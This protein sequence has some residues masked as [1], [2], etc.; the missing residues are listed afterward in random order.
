MSLDH[1]EGLL[2]EG[3]IL[4][5]V[6]PFAAVNRPSLPA[7][8][9]QACAL[10]AGF[11]VSVLY[12]NLLLAAEIGV[13]LYASVS[14]APPHAMVGERFFARSAH[15]LPPFGEPEGTELASHTFFAQARI[16]ESSPVLREVHL[17]DTGFGALPSPTLGIDL[18]ELARFEARAG[19]FADAIALAVA[20]RPFKVVGA[21]TTFEQTN[22]SLALLQRIK[23][24]RPAVVTILGGANCEGEM[25]EGIASLDPS[26]DHIFSGESDI[27]FPAFLSALFSS[28]ARSGARPEGRIVK[29]APVRDL[30][31]I[32]TPDFTEYFE[33][34]SSIFPASPS[35]SSGEALGPTRLP[36]ETSRGCWWGQKHHCTF[37]GLNGEGMAFREKSA[38]RV[39][40]DLTSLAAA[41]ET[42][43]FCMT[44]N[45]MP[46][47][48]FKSLLPRLAA[49]PSPVELF[50]EQKANLSL[51][52]VLTLKRAG[53][54]SIQPGI[55]ALSSA[56]LRRMDKGVLARQ[57]LVLLRDARAAGLDLQWNLLWGFPGDEAES[58]ADTLALLPLLHH[59]QPPSCFLH[60]S[61]DRFSPYFQRPEA[62]GI[63]NLRPHPAYRAAFPAHTAIDQLAYYF[64]GDYASSG[65]RRLD[66]IR[67]IE[68]EL[69]AWRAR[70]APSAG[71][72]PTRPTPPTLRVSPL[73]EHYLVLDTRGLPGTEETMV[74]E[75]EE[76]ASAL[77]AAPYV[78]T[79]AITLAIERRIGVV[80]DGFYVPLA[81]ASPPLLQALEREGRG[82]STWERAALPE[83]GDGRG[84]RL[85][86]I[87]ETGT[88]R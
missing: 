34:R 38:E 19:L 30:D 51:D 68:E 4:I 2:R 43:R 39:F 82:S 8:L 56:L 53:V 18:P 86:V 13:A 73:G 48:Y 45:I 35:L 14:E 1:I 88:P 70:W 62:Y 71:A 26:V 12:A 63:Q 59:L 80:V 37:C 55:E 72:G 23:R 7:H 36:Y 46:R 85:P 28:G 31:A 10:A 65:Y 58:Y 79:A 57:N 15:G 25:A 41:H 60:L 29:G 77:R 50:Y 42:R 17:H 64:V 24:A 9:L 44:D 52:D 74:L 75:R 76:A 32:P 78:E 69:S 54:T 87:P 6:P 33:Q 21:T 47:G 27:T 84:L 20:R 81:T 11:R 83:D 61:I 5:I 22:A 66:L 16:K 49:S 3:E 67:R 40:A